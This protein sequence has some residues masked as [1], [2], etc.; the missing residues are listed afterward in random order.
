MLR[1]GDVDPVMHKPGDHYWHYDGGV[2]WLFQKN[3]AKLTLAASHFVPTTPN[4]PTNP[5]RTEVI[6]AAQAGF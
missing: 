5:Q 4:P 3:E 1:V 2:A 6:L